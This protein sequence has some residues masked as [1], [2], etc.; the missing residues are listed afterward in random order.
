MTVRSNGSSHDGRGAAGS[1]IRLSF[2]NT[3]LL[4]MGGLYALLRP[5]QNKLTFYR[6]TRFQFQPRPDDIFVVTYPKSGTT[7]VLAMLYQLA[8]E[9]NMNFSNINNIY[10]FFAESAADEEWAPDDFNG[11][12]SP[13][14]FRT[15]HRYESFPKYPSR[16]IYVY[17]NGMDVA[18]SFHHYARRHYLPGTFDQHFDSWLHGRGHTGPWASHVAGWFHNR[19]KLNILYLKYEDM[20]ADH[21]GT[22]RK[23]AAFCQFEVK[24]PDMPRILERTSFEFMK[25]NERQFDPSCAHLSH[26]GFFREGKTGAGKVHLNSSQME[27]LKK[28]YMKHLG[29]YHLNYF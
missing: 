15:H 16:F 3:S 29:K 12:S 8:T 21:E 28:Q 27:K 13:R 26:A 20:I 24:A 7:W 4:L 18:A 22:V 11:M 1:R 5:L 10:P 19:S 14:I 23:I 2:L 6:R 17:R 9:G 25:K